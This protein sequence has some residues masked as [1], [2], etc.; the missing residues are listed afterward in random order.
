MPFNLEKVDK[1]TLKPLHPLG[2]GKYFKIYITKIIV[3]DMLHK[4]NPLL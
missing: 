2:N 4:E 1:K 3:K